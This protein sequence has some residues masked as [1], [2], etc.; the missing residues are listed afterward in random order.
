LH[1]SFPAPKESHY[2]V[3]GKHF[4]NLGLCDPAVLSRVILLQKREYRSPVWR[5]EE[6]TIKWGHHYVSTYFAIML[7]GP[8]G[9]TSL[10][11][12]LHKLGLLSL[13]Q[14]PCFHVVQIATECLELS[15]AIKYS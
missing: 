14:S 3:I 9:R 1:N 6:E 8:Q 5:K 12:V 10:S 13:L 4:L 11:S 2:A 15:A 7:P